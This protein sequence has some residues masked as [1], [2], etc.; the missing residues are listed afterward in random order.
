MTLTFT[1]EVSQFSRYVLLIFTVLLFILA[2]AAYFPTAGESSTETVVIIGVAAFLLTG[3]LC[4]ATNA[5]AFTPPSWKPRLLSPPAMLP[6]VSSL[7]SPVH[8]QPH[9]SAKP[10]LRDSVYYRSRLPLHPHQGRRGC[11]PNGSDFWHL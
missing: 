5:L 3:V 2:T 1:T 7:L 4:G 10:L 9:L 11:R 6:W 8:S